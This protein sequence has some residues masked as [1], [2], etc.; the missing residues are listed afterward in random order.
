MVI[1]DTTPLNYLVLIE[2]QDLLPALFVEVFIPEAVLDE[3][4]APA[5]PESV[6]EWV[7]SCPP[8]L[9]TRAIASPPDT[10]LS[11][12][13]DG[14]REAIQLAVESGA[15][16]LLVDEQAARREAVSRGLATSGTLGILDRAAENGLID[17]ALALQRLKQTS[18]YLSPRVEQ[19]FL[20][21]DAKR[22]AG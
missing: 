14:E 4:Q 17:F 1:A 15:A 20:D 9:R 2:A 18:F 8:W 3:L 13:D 10:S 16:L 22:K 21:R 11:H 12:L 5:T 6:R 19:F 7:M